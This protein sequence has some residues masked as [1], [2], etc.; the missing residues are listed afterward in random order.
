M[1]C[2]LNFVVVELL[3]RCVLSLNLHH[4]TFLPSCNE[5]CL[6]LWACIWNP[7]KFYWLWNHR[8]ELPY[9]IYSV[10]VTW[11][12]KISECCLILIFDFFLMS[13]SEDRLFCLLFCQ[14]F[15]PKDRLLDVFH[16]LLLPL[17]VLATTQQLL[18]KKSNLHLITFC[19]IKKQI[20]NPNKKIYR[21]KEGLRMVDQPSVIIS[22]V[23]I[24]DLEIRSKLD[25]IIHGHEHSPQRT[26]QH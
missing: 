13:Y 14:R 17:F 6:S 22:N 15:H 1:G 21:Q 2:V 26:Q 24:E 25:H 18:E 12:V 3:L 23:F 5:P 10:F 8:C 7:L 9:Y 4:F 16:P 19:Q 11:G 20:F